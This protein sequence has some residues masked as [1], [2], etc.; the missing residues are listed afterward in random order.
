MKH[1]K[2]VIKE[3]TNPSGEVVFRVCGS[4]D[5]KRI[6]KNLP[7][8]AEAKAEADAFE[9]QRVQGETGV[10]P[11][12]TRLTEHELHEAEAVVRRLAGKP[13]SLSFYV[14]F[15]LANY[16]EPVCEKSLVEAAAEYVA[17][18]KHEFEQDL[19]SESYFVRLEREMD[20]IP[21]RIPVAT[22]AELTSARLVAYFEFQ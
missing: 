3:F 10:R 12:V 22:V 15:A 9:I 18:K 16:R 13:H 6:R 7:T 21:K 1:A 17:A 20:R 11:T 8:R 4:L 19:I 14:D 5:G 2:F